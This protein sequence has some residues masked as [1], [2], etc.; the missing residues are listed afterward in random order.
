MDPLLML[1]QR[2]NEQD[3]DY[4]L[5]GGMAAIAHGARVVTE[6]VDVCA[7]MSSE[8]IMRIVRAMEGLH[9]KWSRRPGPP[10]LLESV[11]DR[12]EGM[13]NIYLDTDLGVIDFLGE[14]PGV[15]DFEYAKRNS[16]LVPIAPVFK[17]RLLNIDA[18]LACKRAANRPKDQQSIR[19]LEAIRNWGDLFSLHERKDKDSLN[20]D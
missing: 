14:L 15:G 16:S 17:C 1:L 12:L 6:D 20:P 2:L 8:N 5:V 9:A 3:V 10:L 13:K 7:S 11:L 18:L 4:V 19:A